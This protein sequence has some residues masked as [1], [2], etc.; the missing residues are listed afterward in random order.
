[1]KNISVSSL[2]K[3][4]RTFFGSI[5]LTLFIVVV[6]AGLSYAVFTLNDILT[7]ADTGDDSYVSPISAGSIDQTT[8]ERV[9]Q[10]HTST[11]NFSSPNYSGRTNPFNE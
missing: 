3:P 5:H 11:E 10:L 2:L 9:Q 6:A 7:L 8:L 1:M 4:I